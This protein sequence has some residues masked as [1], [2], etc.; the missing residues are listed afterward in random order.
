MSIGK[1]MK[2]NLN[3]TPS[4]NL[5]WIID[6]NVKYQKIKLLNENKG[7]NLWNLGLGEAFLDVILK[8]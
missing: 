8:A 2:F 1:E 5:K 4:I 3:P 7:E 6:L